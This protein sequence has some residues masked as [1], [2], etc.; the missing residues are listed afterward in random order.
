MRTVAAIIISLALI[1]A[2]ALPQLQRARG[3]GG[4]DGEGFGVDKPA[5][6]KASL[7]AVAPLT[8]LL[9]SY[10]TAVSSWAINGRTIST[11]SGTC[12]LT[13]DKSLIASANVVFFQFEVFNHFGD[14]AKSMPPRPN[15]A[16]WV[17][18]TY[19][20]TNLA[21]NQNPESY[22]LVNGSINAVAV[23][24]RNATIS[25]PYGKFSLRPSRDTREFDSIAMVRPKS[26]TIMMSNCNSE[27]RNGLLN[28]LRPH[29]AIDMYG[30]CGNISAQAICKYSHHKNCI[31]DMAKHYLFYL[32]IENSDC[33]DYVTEKVWRNSLDAGMVPIVWS[34]KVDYKG[35]L[36]PHSYINVADFSS[37]EKFADHVK[38]LSE[39]PSAYA[40]YHEWR[41]DYAA[42]SYLGT[43]LEGR[44]ICEFAIKNKH[45]EL[46][47]V[48]L[49]KARPKCS[50]SHQEALAAMQKI[51]G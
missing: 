7:S 27:Y 11:P 17:Y 28:A 2:H 19:E 8:F 13:A 29:L 40:R 33:H 35:L 42:V 16:L 30:I 46:P 14:V 15:G 38:R 18:Y 23:Y 12:L 51:S 47:A 1:H 41:K 24:E 22:P 32:A 4:G 36:P 37:L 34:S 44:E 39:S 50:S 21:F 6:S 49:Y 5:A 3:P 45:K 31:R 43:G 25:I 9:W 48:D 10:G 20:S 26:T